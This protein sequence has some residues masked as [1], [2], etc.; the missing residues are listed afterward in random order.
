MLRDDSTSPA[1][2]PGCQTTLN[3]HVKDLIETEKTGDAKFPDNPSMMAVSRPLFLLGRR[4]SFDFLFATKITPVTTS[5]QDQ[6]I[7]TQ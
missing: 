7:I 6:A 3:F 5:H 1:R 4:F 2:L